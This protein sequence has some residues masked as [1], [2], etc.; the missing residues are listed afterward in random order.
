MG[1][2]MEFFKDFPSFQSLPIEDIA[3]YAAKSLYYKF[4]SNT[5]VIREHDQPNEIFFIKTGRVKVY[6]RKN[7]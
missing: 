1:Q 3:K 4:P 5:V 7:A 6:S 2:I